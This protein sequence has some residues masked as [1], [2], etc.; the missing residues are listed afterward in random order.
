M[1][2]NEAIGSRLKKLR[3]SKNLTQ[4]ELEIISKVHNKTI[5][6]YERGEVKVQIDKLADL[7][8]ALGVTLADF[9]DGVEV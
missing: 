1:T 6:A 8:K 5:G 7:C 4:G 2:I 3:E 9:L